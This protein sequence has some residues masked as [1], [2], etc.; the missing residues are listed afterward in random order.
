MCPRTKEPPTTPAIG[1]D[2]P[3]EPDE[4]VDCAVRLAVITCRMDQLHARLFRVGD[5]DLDP[6]RKSLAKMDR[7]A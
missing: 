7:A 5:I 4:V 1:G 3:G 6:H 2:G